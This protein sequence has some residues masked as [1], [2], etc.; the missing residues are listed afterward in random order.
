MNRFLSPIWASISTFT[1]FVTSFAVA[2]EAIPN[3]SRTVT[4]NGTLSGYVDSIDESGQVELKNGLVVFLWGLHELDVMAVQQLVE[5][6]RLRCREVFSD[7][8]VFI[9]LDCD[10]T[11]SFTIDGGFDHAPLSLLHWLPQLD[12]ATLKCETRDE[13]PDGVIAV[14]SAYGLNYTCVDGMPIRRGFE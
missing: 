8:D 1:V 2:Q 3:Q 14:S 10:V 12:L 5:G 11:S 13:M 4:V 6:K 7:G 9:S